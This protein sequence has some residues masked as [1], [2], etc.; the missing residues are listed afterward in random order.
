MYVKKKNKGAYA[1]NQ[2]LV[3]LLNKINVP[4]YIFYGD[5][6]WVEVLQMKVC[7]SLLC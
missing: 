5:N 3:E 4:V 2:P 6:D 1:T 7:V